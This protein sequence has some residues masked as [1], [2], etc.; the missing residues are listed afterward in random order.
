MLAFRKI[1][2][3]A[4]GAAGA[5]ATVVTFVTDVLQP[6]G[7]FAP[8]VAGG[9]LVIA[10][11]SGAGY[12][13]HWRKPGVDRAEHPLLGLFLL[14]AVFTLFFGAWSFIEA[15]GPK[16]GYLAANVDPIA[17][18]QAQLLGLQKD[19]SAVKQ[20]TQASA[21]T[22]AASATVQAAAATTQAQGF[23]D[24]Q[25]AFARL[26]S[27]GTLSPNPQSPQ[28]W[29]ANA[30]VYQLKGDTPTRSRPMKAFLASAW[31]TWTRTL[32]IPR[33]CAPPMASRGRGRPLTICGASM[34]TA[35][36]SS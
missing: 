36:R 25:A 24:I 18:I 34:P 14:S 12:W 26:S 31:N 27:Q 10:L 4:A 15:N 35:R 17:Q 32:N 9:S 3:N 20:T 29:Y 2:G 8:W 5:L 22:I 30:R 21:T 11:G 6:L 23:Q 19:V 28:E 13:R 16:N 33:C 1:F 7:N